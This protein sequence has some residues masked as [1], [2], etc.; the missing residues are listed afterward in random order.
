MLPV[1]YSMKDLMLVETNQRMASSKS[2]TNNRLLPY[3][4]N[5]KRLFE[6]KKPVTFYVDKTDRRI[7]KQNEKKSEVRSADPLECRWMTSK[8][9]HLIFH[10]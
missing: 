1:N 5:Y 3:P 10:Q 7:I 4:G 9:S 2:K 6:K 8:I